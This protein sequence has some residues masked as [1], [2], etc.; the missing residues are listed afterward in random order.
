MNSILSHLDSVYAIMRSRDSSVSIVMDYGLD[1]RGSNFSRAEK[2]VYFIVS[3]LLW[4][5]PSLL[6]CGYWGICL[7]GK[8]AGTCS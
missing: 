1:F 7:R 8:E 3:T 6:F 2:F 4:C 5:P